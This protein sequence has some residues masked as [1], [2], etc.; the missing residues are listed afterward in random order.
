MTVDSTGHGA[1][2]SGSITGCVDEAGAVVQQ[3][4]NGVR[5]AL[6][7]GRRVDITREK[8]AGAPP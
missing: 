3:K 5:D 8:I 7:D 6:G 1:T 2:E 4:V